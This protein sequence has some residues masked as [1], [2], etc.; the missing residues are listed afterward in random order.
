MNYL[1]PSVLSADFS[2]LGND[3]ATVATAG[4]PII[5]LDVMDGKFVPNISFGAPVIS[6]VR[7]VTDAI[8]DVHL[9]IEEPSRYLEDFS[10]A[11]ADIITVHYEA[12]QDVAATLMQIRELGVKVGLSISPDTPADVLKPFLSQVDMI[13]IMSVYPGFGGQKFIDASIDKIKVV[14]DMADE[15]ELNG[16]WIEVDGGIGADNIVSVMEAGANVFVAGSAVFKGDMVAN[17]K[18]LNAKIQ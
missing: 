14:R 2:T 13:L 4:A 10:K 8:F 7:K 1:A 5:H 9:M 15:L 12:C 6:S 18:A 11:G 16:L 3:I 17:V